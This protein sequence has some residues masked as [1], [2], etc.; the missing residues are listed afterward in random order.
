M[1]GPLPGTRRPV[2]HRGGGITGQPPPWLRRNNRLR[3][4]LDRNHA[5]AGLCELLFWWLGLRPVVSLQTAESSNL[6]S[7]LF[8]YGRGT[9][10]SASAVSSGQDGLV[11]R[12]FAETVLEL[13]HRD[14]D[15]PFVPAE[16]LDLLRLADIQENGVAHGHD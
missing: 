5:R 1:A 3:D 9:R 12:Q 4:W 14:V 15:G 13:R 16:L 2:A 7:V 6:E 8:E 10:G 11:L